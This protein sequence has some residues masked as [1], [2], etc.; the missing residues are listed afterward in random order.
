LRGWVSQ[1]S[2]RE[3]FA[4]SRVRTDFLAFLAEASGTHAFAVTGLR[5]L[6][7]E[8]ESQKISIANGNMLVVGWAQDDPNTPGDILSRPGWQRSQFLQNLAPG[9]IS[10]RYLGWAWITLVYD[11][12]EDDYRHRFAN[13]MKCAHGQAMCDAIGDL[14]HLRNVVTHSKGIATREHAGRCKLLTEW[15]T[16]GHEIMVNVKRISYFDDIISAN[17]TAFYVGRT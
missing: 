15:F 13:E 8:V 10:A 14:R 7:R 6:R 12:W 9:G 1:S 3:A 11:R 4:V 2:E 5:V 17:D 16:I